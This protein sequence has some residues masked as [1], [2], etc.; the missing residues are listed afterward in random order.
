MTGSRVDVLTAV[1]GYRVY[2]AAR[3]VLGGAMQR[4]RS[5]GETTLALFQRTRTVTPLILAARRSG[6]P[7]F[8]IRD[9]FPGDPLAAVALARLARRR[10]IGILET[11]GYKPNVLGRLL[12]PRLRVPWIAFLHGETG[13]GWKVRAYCRLE[14]LAVPRA[15][16]VVAVSVQ[17]ARALAAGGV[18]AER[19]R[20]IHN[21]CQIESD[22]APSG[23]RPP[24]VGVVGRLSPEKGV[25]VALRVHAL[26][27]RRRAD[28][29]LLIAG[30]GRE[31]ERL[32]RLAETLGIASS[33][34]W[35]GYQDDPGFVYR[36]LAVLL[37]PSR[38]EG[39]PNVVL[40][41]LAHG[42]PVVATAIGG[43]PEV[44]SDGRNGFLAP[45]DNVE[46]LAERV[47]QLLEDAPLRQ[48]LG[49]LGREEVLARFSPE[50]RAR[51]MEALYDEVLA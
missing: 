41:T 48:R 24:V 40:E 12:A 6:V 17:M 15:D 11:H 45:V 7:V 4:H 43:V 29:R 5:R 32:R 27:V 9:R 21:A 19:I 50:A 25:D 3:Q 49:Q 13:E 20:V 51:A 38:R 34:H 28:A 10:R 37:L 44:V 42:V 39:L 47:V 33:V 35:L 23:E 14:R 16:R 8:V 30:D 36:Q 18:P 1:D 22:D 46:A 2:G 31:L 26:V